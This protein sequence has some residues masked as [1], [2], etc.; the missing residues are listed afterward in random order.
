M[1]NKMLSRRWERLIRQSFMPYQVTEHPVCMF[2]QNLYFSGEEVQVCFLEVKF[3]EKF[4]RCTEW[5]V[6]AFSSASTFANDKWGQTYKSKGKK[7]KTS[8]SKLPQTNV[9][10]ETVDISWIHVKWS[11]F[12]TLLM[13]KKIRIKSCV[14][15]FSLENAGWYDIEVQ[16]ALIKSESKIHI[17][18]FNFIGKDGEHRLPYSYWGFYSVAKWLN[19]LEVWS[20][21]FNE[22]ISIMNGPFNIHKEKKWQSVCQ[23]PINGV[24]GKMINRKSLAVTLRGDWLQKCATGWEKSGGTGCG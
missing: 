22:A 11:L 17:Y 13:Y 5:L 12:L 7:W 6:V 18:S 3:L 19:P 23:L 10:R 8:G 24:G 1:H 20:C 2:D 15:N 21:F 9:N 14:Q 16:G 4:H